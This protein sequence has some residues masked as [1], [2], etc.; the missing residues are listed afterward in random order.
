[1]TIPSHPDTL[2]RP[3]SPEIYQ[4]I[5][6]RA[7]D[8]ILIWN[9]QDEIILDANPRAEELYGYTRE[10]L[11][12]KS[13]REITV[14]VAR[15]LA[16]TS[17]LL[18]AGRYDNYETLHRHRDG[19]V[20]HVLCNASVIQLRGTTAIL[21]IHRDITEHK[22]VEEEL[23]QRSLHLNALVEATPLGIVVLDRDLR[24]VA[25][26]PAFTA[27]FQ[28]S[29]AEVMGRH[30]D[31]F[32]AGAELQ[33]EARALTQKVTDGQ[34]FR[35]TT[36]RRRKD[37]TLA[38][39]EV[40]GVPLM[41][42]NRLA[43]SLGLYQDVSER[44]SLQ[45]QLLE[46]QK[47]DAVGRLAGG[48][49]H[50]INNML[51]AILIHTQLLQSKVSQEL[52]E[53]TDQIGL[54]AGRAAST[55]QQ[56]LAFSRKQPAYPKVIGLNAAIGELMT[57]LRP[58]I[59]E[60]L[61]FPFAP[62]A[63][64]LYV[65]LDPGHLTQL[66]VNLVVNARDAIAGHGSILLCTDL[67]TLDAETA[68]RLELEP[69]EYASIEVADTGEGMTPEVK[70]RIFEPFYTTKELGKGT[71]L[72][73]ATVYGIVKQG[74]GAIEVSSDVG[75]GSTFRVFFPRQPEPSADESGQG[76]ERLPAGKE[77]ILLVEDEGSTRGAIAE[78]LD[79]LGYNVLQ[80][81][82]GKSAL[83]TYSRH[84]NDIDLVLSDLV[85]PYMNGAELAVEIKKY[86]PGMPVVFVSAYGD[87]EMRAKLAADYVILRKPFQLN[88]LAK[89]LRE[90][91]D[92]R[93][94]KK[95]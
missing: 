92:A 47:L 2:R 49:A 33:E 23:R 18:K 12:G 32:I 38:D 40:M 22:R 11:V 76:Q 81:I 90:K 16:E 28:W 84:K 64:E 50:D 68:R 62:Y 66:L 71:G 88:D 7:N 20:L 86:D 5:F 6:H 89:R 72:G 58:L 87:D 83:E 19:T 60:D 46:S 14:D 45:R 95:P 75:K 43:G 35:M 37:Q 48:V 54:A 55:I 73:L 53:H 93:R 30:L 10:Q 52:R 57:M 21:S 59:R 70:A 41:I 65:R 4:E 51:T 74:Q 24:I 69:G 39:V 31:D 15:G 94:K 82:N 77:T 42:D 9:P 80:A 36:R 13:M 3:L 8:A 1:M 26:N 34:P 67:S 27:I 44:I 61:H 85:M 79:H 25:C 91:L 63:A 56:L 17:K 29:E 78:F